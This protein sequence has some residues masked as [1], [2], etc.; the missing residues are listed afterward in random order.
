[1]TSTQRLL[2]K[3]TNIRSLEKKQTLSLEPGSPF[4]ASKTLLAT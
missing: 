4:K 1:M 2:I 3:S